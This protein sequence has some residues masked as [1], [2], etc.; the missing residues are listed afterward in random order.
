MLIDLI[1]CW[2]VRRGREVVVGVGLRRRDWSLVWRILALREL[3]RRPPSSRPPPL[4]A[5]LDQPQQRRFQRLASDSAL[6]NPAQLIFPAFPCLSPYPPLPSL[7]IPL[8][9]FPLRPFPW[10]ESRPQPE[11]ISWEQPSRR[12]R[13]T[14]PSLP[15]QAVP[16][17]E[18]NARKCERARVKKQRNKMM[19]NAK[20]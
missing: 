10:V 19:Q 12:E 20:P 2:A 14:V 3:R 8:P 11:L 18:E 1:A 13:T 6:P 15:V 5:R 16:S 4:L 7:T 9:H 17:A